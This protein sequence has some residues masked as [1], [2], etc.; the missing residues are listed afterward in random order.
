[1]LVDVCCSLET[2]FT[3]ES[4]RIIGEKAAHYKLLW[5]EIKRVQ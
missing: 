1:M 5:I 4:V 3:G 2:T